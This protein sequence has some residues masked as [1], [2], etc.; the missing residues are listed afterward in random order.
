MANSFNLDPST[1]VFPTERIVLDTPT[2]QQT[3]GLRMPYFP[4]RAPH[5]FLRGQAWHYTSLAAL[6]SILGRQELWSTSWRATNDKTELRHGMSFVQ[7]AWEDFLASNSASEQTRELLSEVGP[8]RDLVD[9]FEHVNMLCAA[10]ERD[11][12]Y[13]WNSYAHGPSGVAIGLDL[14]RPLI[15]DI[16]DRPRHIGAEL[17]G[18][19]WLKVF[20]ASK[21]KELAAARFVREIDSDLRRGQNMGPGVFGALN[22][23]TAL[24]FKHPGFHNEREARCV[25]LSSGVNLQSMPTSREKTIVPWISMPAGSTENRVDLPITEILLSPWA[26]NETAD[27]VRQALHDTGM[28]SVPVHQSELP[29]R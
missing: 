5:T 21:Q 22:V 18:V 24:N 8:L 2:G 23:L 14:S 28:R 1:W 6:Q 12:P 25:S 4:D 9:Y 7:N 15:T 10:R 26:T 11:S 16:D 29:F 17:L 3:T 27:A 20:Y 19:P 13:H